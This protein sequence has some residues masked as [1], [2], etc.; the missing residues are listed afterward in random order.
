MAHVLTRK[1]GYALTRR[2]CVSDSAADGGHAQH[3]SVTTACTRR[4]TGPIVRRQGEKL[5]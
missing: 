4:G 2:N 1:V 5:I 3:D